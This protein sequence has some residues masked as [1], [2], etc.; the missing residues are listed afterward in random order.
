MDTVRHSVIHCLSQLL[1]TVPMPDLL[2]VRDNNV[3][4]RIVYINS[5]GYE[6]ANIL[7]SLCLAT[8]GRCMKLVNEEE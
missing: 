6:I 7:D 2:K 1:L 3:R 4:T 8:I 5:L